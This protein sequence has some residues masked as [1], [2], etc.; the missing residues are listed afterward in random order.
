MIVLICGVRSLCAVKQVDK[1]RADRLKKIT[2]G[3]RRQENHDQQRRC[4]M[5]QKEDVTCSPSILFG[6]INRKKDWRDV[7][8]LK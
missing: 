7:F 5:K 1:N 3:H 8:I 4:D 2:S 6:Q